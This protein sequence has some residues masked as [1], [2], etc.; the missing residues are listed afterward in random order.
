MGEARR[1][2]RRQNYKTQSATWRGSRAEGLGNHQSRTREEKGCGGAGPRRRSRAGEEEGQGGERGLGSGRAEATNPTS[3]T[4]RN[5]G[6]N[7]RYI[8]HLGHISNT[9]TLY[10]FFFLQKWFLFW[11][12]NCGK[13]LYVCC[14]TNLVAHNNRTLLSQSSG[15]QKS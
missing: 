1:G 5:P 8:H 3:P 14:N 7:N 9:D 13:I 2:G 4:P 6:A 12:L 11:G 10:S 15:G